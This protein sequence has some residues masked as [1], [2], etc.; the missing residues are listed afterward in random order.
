VRFQVNGALVPE[1]TQ[2]DPLSVKVYDLSVP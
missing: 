1:Q 2:Y